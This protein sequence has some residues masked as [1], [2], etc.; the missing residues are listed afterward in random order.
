V[1]PCPHQ[2]VCKATI[3]CL[4]PSPPR[5]TPCLSYASTLHH[6][7][8]SLQET[9]LRPNWVKG[10]RAL[11]QAETSRANLLNPPSPLLPRVSKCQ[12][13][14][15]GRA[16]IP[17]SSEC[18]DLLS[19]ILVGRPERR[20]TIQQIQQHPWYVICPPHIVHA[21]SSA[22][23]PLLGIPSQRTKQGP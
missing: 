21:H 18:K 1:I 16:D 11:F 5:L 2:R 14:N 3:V 10:H 6:V 4:I 20:Y 13:C 12:D 23:Q 7:S 17:V 8:V 15:N 22:Y 19:K 9:F